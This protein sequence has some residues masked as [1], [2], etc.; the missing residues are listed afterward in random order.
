[1]RPDFARTVEIHRKPGYDPVE[2]FLDPAIRFPA[3]AIGWRLTKR[4]LGMRT[5]MDV[6]PLDAGLVRGSHGRAD[7]SPDQGPVVMSSDPR[8]L[9]A[10]DVAATQ[11]KQLMID[12]IFGDARLAD[13]T[14]VMERARP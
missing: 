1:M 6:I 5:L 2:L 7:N 9:P 8:L 14:W 10:G 4:A 13:D 11:I 3:L 12:H